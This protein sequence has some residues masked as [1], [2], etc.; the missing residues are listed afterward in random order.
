V[1]AQQKRDERGVGDGSGGGSGIAPPP[2]SST[3][4]RPRP[5]GAY[6]DDGDGDDEGRPVIRPSWSQPQQQQQQKPRPLAPPPAPMP[7]PPARAPPPSGRTASAGAAASTATAGSAGGGAA[8][9]AN[10]Q[11]A[12]RAAQAAAASAAARAAS[13]AAT[14]ASDKPPPARHNA[15]STNNNNANADFDAALRREAELESLQADREWY[16]GDDDFCAG[17]GA[18]AGGGGAGGGAADLPGASPTDA[19]FE[20]RAAEMQRRLRRAD[21]SLMSYAA[22]H[23]AAERERAADA[24]EATRLRGAGGAGGGAAA[25]FGG[26]DADEDSRVVLLVHDTTPPFLQAARAGAS[27]SAVALAAAGASSSSVQQEVVSPVLDPTGDMA[28]IA[29][30]GSALVR[31]M[32]EKRDAAKSRA[33]FWDVAGSR[34]G[35]ITGLTG[36]EAREAA[37]RA[38][39]AADEDD[40]GGGGD[41]D[42]AAAAAGGAAAADDEDNK[43]KKDYRAANQY[44]SHV[45]KGGGGAAAGDGGNGNGNDGGANKEQRRRDGAASEFSRTR[46]L[47]QQR[48]SLPVYAVRDELLQLIR[49]NPVVVVV[50]ETGSGKTTQLTQ[51]LAEDGYTKLGLVGCTQ[52]RRV[53]AVSVAKRVADEMGV[54]LGGEVGYSIRFEDCTSD[55]TRIKYMTDGVLLRETLNNPTSNANGGGAGGGGGED[56]WRYKAVVMDEAHER[57]L[58]T[59]VLFGVLRRVVASRSDFRLIVTSATLDADRFASFFGGCPV[60]TIPGRTFPVDVLWSRSP[61][62]DYVEAAVKQALAIHLRDPPGDILIFLTG[63]EE[64][65]AACFALQERLDRMREAV[66]QAAASAAAVA[67]ESVEAGGDGT[68]AASSAAAAAEAAAKIPELV[69]LPIYSQLPADLQARIFERAAPGQR[70]CVVATNIAETSLTLDGVYYVI[71]AG[72]SKLKVYNPRVGMDALQVF[73]ESQAA[74]DQ[75]SGRA[76]RTGPGT[77]YRLFTERAYSREMRRATV[78]EIQRTNLSNVVLLLK[79]LRVDDVLSFGFMDPPPRETLVAALRQLWALGA[80]DGAGR[81]TAGGRHM[82]EFPLDPPLARL[83]LAGARLGCAAD[84]ATVVSMLSV[85]TV[86]FRPP[87]RAEESD[88]AREKFCVPESDHLTLLNVFNQWHSH[89]RRADWCDKH[90]LQAKALRR[91]DEVRGQIVDLL[92]QRGL[93]GGGSSSSAAAAAVKPGATD[94]DAVRRAVCA[95]YFGNAA[96]FKAVGEYLNC[97]TGA[98]A[99][100]HPSSALF[101]LGH[102]PNYVVY[103]ELVLTTKE[104][105]QAVTA[106]EP[107]WLAEAGPMFFSVRVA[108]GGGGGGGGEEEGGGGRAGGELS[109]RQEARQ[110]AQEAEARM[111]AEFAAAER[112]RSEAEAAAAERAAAERERAARRQ[113]LAGVA[114]GGGRGGG[115]GGGGLALRRGGRRGGGFFGM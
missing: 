2:P 37:E 112:E 94:W 93:F 21:G 82:A 55:K 108:G 80:L 33:R 31:E 77:C 89:G 97:R 36:G 70:K 24:W 61:Q 41:E 13:A 104:Y 84:A 28:M 101:G 99:F 53:A 92:R 39:A 111:E 46:T 4:K 12:I 10:I 109:A 8:A 17:G 66:A 65:E 110:R 86:F 63:Q 114:A 79:S 73:P 29:R 107:E 71:D 50:G 15:S 30:Q 26:D 27:G 42:N 22:S 19:R 57:S 32:R 78:P 76:G 6:D 75:R 59:D 96:K 20:K 43:R 45:D 48:R 98:P 40:G 9:A 47:A 81:L 38:A 72:Y 58:N 3:S 83:L 56:L 113:G 49:E 68:A 74:A 34:M 95:A 115:R 5:T 14:S 52:P 105:M 88:A 11:A 44:R 67:K 62:Q 7:P 25:H 18:H 35:A 16:D 102:V 23:R 87:D 85:P 64:I 51:Y 69:V 103:H 1:L 54:E 106:V 91:A 60:F 100:L 90:F